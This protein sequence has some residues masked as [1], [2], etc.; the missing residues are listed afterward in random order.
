MGRFADSHQRNGFNG[1]MTWRCSSRKIRKVRKI[2]A[3]AW[4]DWSIPI[5]K[6]PE[7]RPWS[8][9]QDAQSGSFAGGECVQAGMLGVDEA[10]ATLPFGESVLARDRWFP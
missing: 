8:R 3:V 9:D 10:K 4:A 6:G 1:R 5:K 2:V 7:E